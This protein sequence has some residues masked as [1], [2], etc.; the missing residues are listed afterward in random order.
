MIQPFQKKFCQ[1]HNGDLRILLRH[2]AKPDS[3]AIRVCKNI[4]WIKQQLFRPQQIPL[5]HIQMATDSHQQLQYL[6][7][8]NSP[9]LIQARHRLLP[10]N[11]IIQIQFSVGAGA[12]KRQQPRYP[13]LLHHRNTIIISDCLL[14]SL[15]HQIIILKIPLKFCFHRLPPSLLR[16]IPLFFRIQSDGFSVWTCQL[17]EI[18]S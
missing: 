9:S 18:F 8:A 14:L 15:D 17:F 11:L 7:V 13:V 1:L 10:G 6:L 4:L 16:M 2:I 12:V 3:P 5:K